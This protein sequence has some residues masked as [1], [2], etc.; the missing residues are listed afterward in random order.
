MPTRV[1]Y[2]HAGLVAFGVNHAAVP[3]LFLGRLE[4]TVD[5]SGVH[6]HGAADEHGQRPRI[7]GSDSFL[8]SGG[9]LN[10]LRKKR[11]TLHEAIDNNRKGEVWQ[12]W[13]F[14][15]ASAPAAASNLPLSFL[16]CRNLYSSRFIEKC[17]A[18]R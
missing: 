7:V 15:L 14:M 6:A 2:A 1:L 3:P 5:H 16:P 10:A 13:E 8:S 9:I 11:T 12:W 18:H 17:F 4:K